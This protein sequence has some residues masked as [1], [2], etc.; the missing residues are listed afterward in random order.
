MTFDPIRYIGAVTRVVENRDR[1]GRPARVVVATRDYPTT[2]GDLWD[3]L[4]NPERIPRW[5]LPVSGDLRL[6][7]RYQ[8][9]GNAGGTITACAPPKQL[10]VTWEYGGE[11]SWLTVTLEPTPTE[12]TRLTLEHVAHVDDPR[13]DQFGPGAVG[14]GMGHGIAR[15][16]LFT[17]PRATPSMR[18]KPPAGSPATPGKDFLRIASDDWAR[19]SIAAG[20]PRDAAL[21]AAER[22]RAAYTGEPAGRELMHAFDVLGDPV[23]RRILELLADGEHASGDVVTVVETEFGI[24]QAAV[25]QHLESA[26]RQ[27]LRVCARRRRAAHLCHRRRTDARGRRMA[28]EVPH[29]LDAPARRPGDRSGARQAGARERGG[30]A[31]T[32][33][34]PPSTVMTCPVTYASRIK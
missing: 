24:S 26:A 16:W 4:T 14:L 34:A 8:F 23:R 22:T 28:A 7:G 11:V 29:L 30:A 15:P 10:E 17:S 9:Q 33:A 6:G 2:A 21:A 12:S 19:A 32:S 1:D 13:W 18:R 5:F 27:R 31:H 3:A 25:S 20:T